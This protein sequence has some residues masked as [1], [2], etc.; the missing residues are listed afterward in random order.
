MI[1]TSR[2]AL[3]RAGALAATAT[4]LVAP[5]AAAAAGG[6]GSPDAL[7]GERAGTARRL[8]VRS[9][10][11]PVRGAGFTVVEPT[12][13]WRMRLTDIGDLSPDRP[14]DE[15]AFT[16]T[17]ASPV[18]GPSQGTFVVRRTGFP[19][20]TLF[21]VPSDHERRTYQAIVNSR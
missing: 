15:H 17:F 19:A 18:P 20:T 21:L 4:P 2:R 14:G 6:A 12:G 7:G 13:R 16:L 3:I 5:A 11:T 8:Y 9:R 10:F 1:E